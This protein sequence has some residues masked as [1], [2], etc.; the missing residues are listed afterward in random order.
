M[1]S[2]DIVCLRAVRDCVA[3][4]IG[5]IKLLSRP[6]KREPLAQ[7]ATSNP[8]SML[9]L[10]VHDDSR[11]IDSENC[12]SSFELRNAVL[13]RIQSLGIE[14]DAVA[15]FGSQGIMIVD[16]SVGHLDRDEWLV[17]LKTLETE[18]GQELRVDIRIK[19]EFCTPIQLEHRGSDLSTPCAQPPT[20]TP[21]NQRFAI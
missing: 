13:G 12:L 6:V 14:F 19:V 5:R 1:S 21:G 17:L 16:Q 11:F 15:P 2:A 8:E 3:R 18:L 7:P 9:A 4:S 20:T 10:H